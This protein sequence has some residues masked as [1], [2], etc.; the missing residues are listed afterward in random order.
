MYLS[1]AAGFGAWANPALIVVTAFIGIALPT[2]SRLSNRIE[3]RVNYALVLVTT[4]R[5]ARFGAQFAF[6][7]A[8]FLIIQLGG[9]FGDTNL[10]ALGGIV[11]AAALTTAA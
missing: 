2:Y 10:S 11:G 5:L 9:V 7:L 8:A 3:Q 6:N 4:G 1:Y